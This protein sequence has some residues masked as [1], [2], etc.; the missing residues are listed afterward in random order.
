MLH[1]RGYPTAITSAPAEYDN[2]R[3]L[4]LLEKLNS[5]D[6]NKVDKKNKKGKELLI[7]KCEYSPLLAKLQLHRKFCK[8][9]R[10]LRAHLG[11][12]FLDTGRLVIARP[13][14]ANAFLETHAYNFPYENAKKCGKKRA[15]SGSGA[16]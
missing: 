3:R 15:G 2:E 12:A 13:V 10:K 11:D 8:L 14:H 5:R 1:K 7:L 4:E 16:L 9:L 6:N